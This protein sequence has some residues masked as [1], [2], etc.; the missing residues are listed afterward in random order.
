LQISAQGLSA[1]AHPTHPL[2]SDMD[3]I[4]N[5]PRPAAAAKASVVILTGFLGAGKTTLLNRI[6]MSEHGR[7]VAVIVNEFGEVGIDHHLLV[8]S[9]QQVVQMNN[10]CICCSINGDLISS[11]F[12]L[13]D[14]RSSFDK[15]VIETTGLAEPAPVAQALYVD[16]RIRREF[17]LD[18]VVTLVDAKHIGAQLE[19]SPE[20]AEQIAFADTILL[21]KTDLVAPEEL[22]A[23]EAKLAGINETAA[24]LRTRNSEMDVARLFDARRNVFSPRL[25]AATAPGEGCEIPSD[26]PDCDGHREDHDHCDG[27]HQAPAHHLKRIAT[28]CIAEPGMVDGLRLSLWFRTLIAECGD[29]LLRM[30]GILNLRGDADEFLFQG[31]QMEFEGK[32]GR[33][34]SAGEERI[35]RLVFIGR[36][37]DTEKVRAGFLAC[38]SVPGDPAVAAGDPFGRVNVEISPAR[39]DQI[40]YW[41]RQNFG[42]PKE[43]SP[44]REAGMSAG[45][46]RHRRGTEERTATPV[47]GA[48][49]DR[50]DHL[51]SRLR[52]DRE[53]DA[54]LLRRRIAGA[55]RAPF[56]RRPTRERPESR[57]V[58][59]REGG[60]PS[61]HVAID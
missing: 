43:G 21:N 35:N 59:P 12:R 51:R 9:D 23:L 25:P 4:N 13:I 39:L 28:V 5:A 7:R 20:A 56:G 10:G 37:L 15:V 57:T 40:R 58:M 32:P 47:Q 36:H 55:A 17:T 24:I 30:K 52:P 19:N 8:S 50:R 2:V 33:P 41:M 3:R 29:N 22:D 11:L 6:L 61:N 16:E 38:L 53:P 49:P 31:V 44:V 34:W 26:G 45:R 27:H 60:A 54:V 42:F 18:G 46:D 48:A 1:F 14:L